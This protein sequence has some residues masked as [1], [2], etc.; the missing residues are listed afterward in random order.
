MD[1]SDK[2]NLALS[3]SSFLLAALSIVFVVITLRQNSKM[4]ENSTRPYIAIYGTYTNFETP[5]YHLVIK[6][7]GTSGARIENFHVSE[8]ILDYSPA[9]E[10]KPFST[11]KGAFFAP[12]QSRICSLDSR[13]MSENM[14]PFEFD[15]TYSSGKKK[16]SEHFTVSPVSDISNIKMRAATKNHELKIISYSLQEFVERFL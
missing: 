12:N 5:T 3:I 4:I 1:L 9:K 13:F 2:I 6:N 14:K 11:L 16:Y 10:L 15:I 7:F 8:N